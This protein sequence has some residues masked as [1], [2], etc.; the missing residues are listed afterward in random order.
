M[1]GGGGRRVRRGHSRGDGERTLQAGKE[2]V[3]TGEEISG[4]S[5]PLDGLTDEIRISTVVRPD[6]W[7]GATYRN[8]SNAHKLPVLGRRGT[9]R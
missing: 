9:E 1:H 2:G 8:L 7:L 3:G 5:N 6:A 4:V